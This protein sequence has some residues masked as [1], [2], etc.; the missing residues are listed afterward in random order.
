MAIQSP[1]E[2][3]KFLTCASSLHLSLIFPQ[4]WVS[5][6][7]CDAVVRFFCF[8]L[9][10]SGSLY[11]RLKAASLG[12]S[13]SSSSLVACFQFNVKNH[14]IIFIYFSVG[15]HFFVRREPLADVWLSCLLVTTLRWNFQSLCIFYFF[16]FFFKGCSSCTE[17]W[18][19][20]LQST[21]P[22]T[23]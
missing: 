15:R 5:V 3:I 9:R 12:R 1:Y 21:A 4:R 22:S 11:F 18:E 17:T 8:V 7:P 2:L 13:S 10:L 14:E 6:S 20:H 23:V 16:F 19:E